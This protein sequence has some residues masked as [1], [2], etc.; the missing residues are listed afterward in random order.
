MRECETDGSHILTFKLYYLFI[1]I[2]IKVIHIE[3]NY[4]QLEY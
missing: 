2:K 4:I 3:I 1:D